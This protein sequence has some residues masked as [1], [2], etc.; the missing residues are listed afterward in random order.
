MI[1]LGLGSNLSSTFGNRFKNID[2]A[3]NYLEKFSVK[4]LKISSYYETPSYPNKKEPK[5]INIVIKI[6][7]DLSPQKLAKIIIK[8]ESL[9][10]RKRNKKNDPRT[11]DID[12]IDF[13][14]Q[15]LNFKFEEFEFLVPHAKLSYRNFV[16]FPL[17]E[18]MPDWIH[19]ITKESINQLIEKL[20]DEEKNS[21]LKVDKS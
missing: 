18:I 3:L 11:C 14:N 5:F 16:L 9:L 8:I 21:I 6:S 17:K 13:D 15:N 20:S 12:I 1:I 4:I 10:E 19:P 2:L 7:T